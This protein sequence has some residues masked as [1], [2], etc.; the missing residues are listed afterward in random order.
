[1]QMIPRFIATKARDSILAFQVR[2]LWWRWPI[3]QRKDFAGFVYP[4]KLAH[5]PKAAFEGAAPF[6]V[7]R[8]SDVVLAVEVLGKLY[9]LVIQR[10]DERS[11]QGRR[12]IAP[13]PLH[14][15][16]CGG[17]VP[18]GPSVFIS[19]PAAALLHLRRDSGVT[20]DRLNKLFLVGDGR[21]YF[22]KE[23]RFTVVDRKTMR[24]T[25][26]T[27]SSVCSFDTSN[28]T[29]VAVMAPAKR[30]PKITTGP[31]AAAAFF[32]DQRWFARNRHL[33]NDYARKVFGAIFDGLSK[34][35]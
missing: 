22:P 14:L 18:T 4:G 32:M 24:E 34:L 21:T 31:G 27:V 16:S 17:K 12:A 15:W 29:Y 19:E 33:F 1:M 20:A 28:A 8:C 7:R 11:E 2:P 30:L 5:A 13:I 25:D 26:R 23:D 35:G 9:L 10:K 6:I 3:M